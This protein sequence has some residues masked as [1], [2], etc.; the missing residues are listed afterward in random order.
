MSKTIT[1]LL[2]FIS[3]QV[4]SQSDAKRWMLDLKQDFGFDN[5]MVSTMKSIHIYIDGINVYSA[6]KISKSYFSG[7]PDF[8]E[9]ESFKVK[10]IIENDKGKKIV[11]KKK[12]ANQELLGFEIE[13]PITEKVN[14][15]L[16]EDL[17]SVKVIS[18]Y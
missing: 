11:L 6:Q 3:L 7:K 1:T 17:T 12:Y 16:E 13:F 15:D 4:F 5:N 14:E 8:K 9:N 2:L 10:I 18:G